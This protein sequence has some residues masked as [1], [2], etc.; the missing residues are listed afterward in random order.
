MRLQDNGQVI[1][2]QQR[3][4]DETSNKTLG[5][6]W[7]ARKKSGLAF[8]IEYLNYRNE[9]TSPTLLSNGEARTDVL[10]FGAKKYFIDSGVFHPYLGAGVGPGRTDISYSS[11]GVS[12]SEEDFAIVLHA[13]LGMELRFDN[14]SFM[15]EARH[16]YF[17]VDA[18]QYDPTATGVL[19]GMGFNW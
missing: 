13:A 14:L 17:N 8:S 16:I 15:L 3:D 10:Q 11:G 6:G 18:N 4:L 5:I 19:A 1:D 12:N 9:F 7:E 2:T